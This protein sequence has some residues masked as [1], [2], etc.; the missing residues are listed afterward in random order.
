MDHTRTSR[1]NHHRLQEG[2]PNRLG[3]DHLQAYLVARETV[4]RLKC[5]SS[6][7]FA[8][9]WQPVSKSADKR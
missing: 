8:H 7:C 4:R 6:P 5:S 9:D 1:A 3:V 2:R